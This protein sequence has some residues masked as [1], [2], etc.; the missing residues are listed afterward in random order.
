MRHYYAMQSPRGF[1]NEITILRFASRAAR[2]RWVDKH[3]SDGDVN[4]AS[5]GGKPCTADE[6]RRILADR[7]DAMTATYHR[8]IDVEAEVLDVCLAIEETTEREEV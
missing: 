6:A 1:A 8:M 7:G 5:Q 4:S 2:D 3:R